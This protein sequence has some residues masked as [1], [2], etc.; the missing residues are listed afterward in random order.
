MGII[1]MWCG[2]YRLALRQNV[3]ALFST[4][5]HT[6][7]H[8]R[9]ARNSDSSNISIQLNIIVE[10]LPYN[11]LCYIQ[12]DGMYYVLILFRIS[13]K[14]LSRM[15]GIHQSN[16]T[17]VLKEKPGFQPRRRV[18]SVM[19]LSFWWL[20][21]V[22]KDFQLVVSAMRRWDFDW[23]FIGCSWQFG[24]STALICPAS[25]QRHSMNGDVSFACLH[26]A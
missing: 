3:V 26:L 21:G 24:P 19:L 7:I 9:F 6:H 16:I 23:V 12:M 13:N 20:Y 11:L 8:E 2:A 22:V 18:L 1:I 5:T 17:W 15:F 4:W 25:R 10:C 14:E